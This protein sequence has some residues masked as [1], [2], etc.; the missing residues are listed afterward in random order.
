MIRLELIEMAEPSANALED[1]KLYAGVVDNGQDKLLFNA[2]ATAMDKVQRTADIALLSGRWKVCAEDYPRVLNVYMGG[3][4]V[5]ATDS[6][7]NAVSFN[8]R[9]RRVYV[10]SDDYVEVE[11]TT[12]VIPAEYAR[13]L[14]VVCEYATALYDGQTDSRILN[15]ILSQCL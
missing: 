2:L 5:S 12:E 9:G 11:F 3:R 13:L 1:L 10:G 15:Q 4:V 7:G 8:Q 6:N 14:P